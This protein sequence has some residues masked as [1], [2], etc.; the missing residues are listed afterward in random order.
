MK[1][2]WDSLEAAFTFQLRYYIVCR[3]KFPPVATNIGMSHVK[4]LILAGI[5][6]STMLSHA[7]TYDL[8]SDWSD[9]SNPNSPWAYTS[10][11]TPLSSTTRTSDA[12]SSPQTSWGDLPGWFRSNG[13]E[14]FTHDWLAG[15]IITHT[16]ASEI[17]WTSPL[18]GTINISGGAWAGR[19]IGRFNDWT[20]SL[21]AVPLTS[22]T[23]GSDDPYNR[24]NPF[25]FSTGSGGLAAITAIPVGIGDVIELRLV[26]QGTGDYAGV[27]FTIV[28]VPEPTVFAY[29]G[30]G[31]VGLLIFRRKKARQPRA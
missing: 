31:V 10:I 4:T 3:R 20:I 24:N 22:G 27:N 13:T 14:Q 2:N 1:T 16:G 12:W 15:D 7:Q 21:N 30:L 29:G 25:A 19:D 9:A 11:G 6:C 28:T 23:I 26:P 8:K 5:I 17:R 18:V